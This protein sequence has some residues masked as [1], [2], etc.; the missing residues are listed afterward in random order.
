MTLLNPQLEQMERQSE[1]AQE[2]IVSWWHDWRTFLRLRT[3]QLDLRATTS[4]VAPTFDDDDAPATTRWAALAEQLARIPSER[5][6]VFE[7]V[8]AQRIESVRRATVAAGADDPLRGLSAATSDEASVERQALLSLQAEADKGGVPTAGDVWYDLDVARISSVP[9]PHAYK[10]GVRLNQRTQSILAGFGLVA[11]LIGLAVFFFFPWPDRATTATAAI[12]V[13]PGLT[14]NDAAVAPWSLRAIQRDSEAP[15]ALGGRGATWP[16]TDAASP[17]LRADQVYPLELCLPDG[18]EAPAPVPS[19][20]TLLGA[21]GAADRVYLLTP[22]EEGV[23]PTDLRLS[24]CGDGA[25]LASGVL[26]ELRPIAVLAVGAAQ[27]L[28]A[29]GALQVQ[30]VAVV[31]AAEDPQI[32]S[33]MAE[34]RVDVQADGGV[35]WLTLSPTLVSEQGQSWGQSGLRPLDGG[36]IQIVHLIAAPEGVQSALWQLTDPLSHAVARWS[37]EI[38]PPRTRLAILTT[39]TRLEVVGA[40][41]DAAGLLLLDLR[42]TNTGDTPLRLQPTDLELFQDDT[43]LAAPAIERGEQMIAPGETVT[44]T[45]TGVAD[46]ARPV[47]VYLGVAG[48]TIGA[49][50]GR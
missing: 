3:E 32:P 43:P 26:A 19:R 2:L 45:A 27:P 22:A 1:L 13:P 23:A 11:T 38:A 25:L 36:A 37:L 35:D 40:A 18:N 20:L 21:E 41:W 44:V 29:L 15:V 46:P 24:R 6:S 17:T 5:R 34:I 28:G 7:R 33:G 48:F 12:N 9:A 50:E 16:P 30:Q 47:Q 31:G 4:A 14:V 49:V 42:V 10:G 8:T 39:A